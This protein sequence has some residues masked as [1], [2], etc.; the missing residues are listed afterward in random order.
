MCNGHLHILFARN[1]KGITFPRIGDLAVL[2][3][4][5]IMRDACD[6]ARCD[7]RYLT[8]QYFDLIAYVSPI[9][10]WNELRLVGGIDIGGLF[11]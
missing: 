10:N 8:Y 11:R 4:T 1:E 9:V 5:E 3:R 7:V 6:T 2:W